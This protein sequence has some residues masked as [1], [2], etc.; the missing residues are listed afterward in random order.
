MAKKPPSKDYRRDGSTGYIPA[1]QRPKRPARI[2]SG[3]KQAQ[4]AVFI[5]HSALNDP[6]SSDDL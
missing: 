4:T 3:P 1:E 6:T 5:P 2:D